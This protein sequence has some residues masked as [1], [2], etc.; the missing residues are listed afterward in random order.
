VHLLLLSGIG[1]PYDPV[2]QTG[3]VGKNY[4]YQT[5]AGQRCSS[6]ANISTRS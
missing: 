3:V 5:G 4:C 2:A 1:T 6:R